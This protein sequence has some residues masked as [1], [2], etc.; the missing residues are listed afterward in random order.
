MNPTS[1]Y[2]LDRHTS[3]TD[4]GINFLENHENIQ[5]IWNLCLRLSSSCNNMELCQQH[6]QLL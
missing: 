1:V 6:P 2:V 3:F 5:V 4:F